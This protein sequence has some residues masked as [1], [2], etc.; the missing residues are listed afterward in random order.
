MHYSWHL[1]QKALRELMDSKHGRT[2]LRLQVLIA[3]AFIALL[4]AAPIA[5]ESER[6]PPPISAQEEKAR[7]ARATVRAEYHR[8]AV[9][10]ERRRKW[11]QQKYSEDKRIA[12]GK[13]ER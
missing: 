1:R 13:E 9:L 8:K 4:L 7:T 5:V 3:V 12:G 2:R 11:E 6:K 10:D